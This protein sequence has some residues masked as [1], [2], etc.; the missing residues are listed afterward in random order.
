MRSL[1]DMCTSVVMSALLQQR[2]LDPDQLQ[3][4]LPDYVPPRVK[5]LI[6]HNFKAHTH[7]LFV[8]DR[9]PYLHLKQKKGEKERGEIDYDT[10]TLLNL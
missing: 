4:R 8:M 2:C 9:L 3:V 1:G 7:Q 6:I 5:H 10:S